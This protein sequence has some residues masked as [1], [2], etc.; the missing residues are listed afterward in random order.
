[1]T[2]I[3]S[4]FPLFNGLN[5]AINL[6]YTQALIHQWLDFCMAFP[7]LARAATNF[8][9]SVIAKPDGVV[10]LSGCNGTDG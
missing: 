10:V 4:G 2:Q 3:S 8:R 5:D 6:T 9:T 7:A 1:M